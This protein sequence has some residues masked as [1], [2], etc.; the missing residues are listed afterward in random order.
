MDK[1]QKLEYW[2]EWTSKNESA[3]AGE[4]GKMDHRERLYRGEEEYITPLTTLDTSRDN[5]P[6]KIIHLRN[7][8][9]E[10][11]ESTISSTIPQPKV[12]ARRKADEG[13][14]KV[15]EDMLRNELDRLPME[16]LNDQIER[17]IP[18]QGGAFWLVEWD[19]RIRTH[20]TVGDVRVS[21]IH[22]KQV[23]PQD[24]VYTRLEDMDAVVLKIPQTKAYI[25]SVYGKKLE[26]EG[27]ENPEVR[28]LDGDTSDAEDLVTQ[29]V[30]YYRN[31]RGGVGKFSWVGDVVIEDMEDY[32][33]RHLRRC[34]ACGTV[35]PPGETACPECGSKG[36]AEHEEEDEEVFRPISTAMGTKIPGAQEGTDEA[37]M[38]MMIPTK[39]PNYKPDVFPVFLQR[40]ISVFGRLLGDSDVDKIEDQQNTMNRI[41]KKIIDRLVKAGTRITLPDRP[42]FRMDPEDGEKWYIG[43]PADKQLIDVMQF[44]GDLRYEMEYY[45]AVYEE[46]RQI[47]GITDSWQGRHDTTATSGVAK[48]YAAAQSAGRLE[49]KRVLKETAYAELFR[50]IVQLKVAYADEPRPV[51][52]TDNRGN[53]KYSEFDRHD[54]YEM[55]E[56]GQW[57]CI[58]DDDRFL[59]SCDT[60]SPLANNREMMWQDCTAQLQM[61][62]FGNPQDINTLILY[63]TKM[64]LLHYPG[65]EDTLE[66]LEQLAQQQMAQQAQ[67]AAQQAAMQEAQRQQERQYAQQDQERQLAIQQQDQARRDAY[68]TV[69][70]RLAAQQAQARTAAQQNQ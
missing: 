56:T 6:N 4:L 13:R 43:N 69:Q 10:N 23:V 37:G 51:V 41:E 8:I 55:D 66:Y 64:R 49:S 68:Q 28:G 14:A 60:S 27:E 67:M 34:T 29:Y 3:F 9:S 7:I 40:N 54:F 45:N 25:K 17:T 46:A 39:L 19:N 32:E 11:I 16:E 33:A 58:L 5:R 22:P 70:Q 57:H 26:Q 42:D 59:F 44:S 61:G 36:A 53:S 18:I 35:V 38:P 47:L 24:G 65:A 21:V 52:S 48:Q 1:Q 50:R 63:W 2:Q 62:A 20:S 31:S 12:T 30:A 15:L